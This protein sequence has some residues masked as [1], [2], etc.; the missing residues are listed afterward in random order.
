L[1]WEKLR[2]SN[3][4][5]G[6]VVIQMLPL[7]GMRLPVWRIQ[8]ADLQHKTEHIEVFPNRAR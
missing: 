1:R 4:K 2:Q 6:F 7:A 8:G 3:G 5:E